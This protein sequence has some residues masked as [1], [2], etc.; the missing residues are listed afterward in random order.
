MARI[1]REGFMV[2]ARPSL[3]AQ[4]QGEGC[5]E[6][7][8]RAASSRDRSVS[9]KAP[10]PTRPGA[11]LRPYSTKHTRKRQR[12]HGSGPSNKEGL[13][14][15]FNAKT[16]RISR[17]VVGIQLRHRMKSPGQSHPSRK[18]YSMIW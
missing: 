10:A 2:T 16:H 13:R 1:Q 9:R 15:S 8:S 11:A 7:G 14:A 3:A 12:P 5:S 18:N 4:F 17:L 6:I